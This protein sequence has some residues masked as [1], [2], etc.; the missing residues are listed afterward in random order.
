MT[1]EDFAINVRAGG[2]A[3]T[4]RYARLAQE[5]G[6]HWSE[7]ASRRFCFDRLA[8]SPEALEALSKSDVLGFFKEYLVHTAAQRRKL[9]VRVLGTSSSDTTCKDVADSTVLRNLA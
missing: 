5:T 4:Q 3:Q 9:S 2:S 1:E 6:R 8:K 7:I